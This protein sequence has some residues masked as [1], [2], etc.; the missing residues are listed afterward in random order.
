MKYKALKKA[1]LQSLMEEDGGLES[2]M[3]KD[4]RQRQDSWGREFRKD[5]E[6]RARAENRGLEGKKDEGNGIVSFEIP[7]TFDGQM[8]L[9]KLLNKYWG[10]SNGSIRASRYFERTQTTEFHIG[11]HSRTENCTP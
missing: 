7:V 11:W 8:A 6:N 5:L 10:T 1:A 4:P 3:G 2:F 9:D